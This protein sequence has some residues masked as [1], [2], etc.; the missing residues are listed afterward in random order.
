[1]M[2]RASAVY[3]WIVAFS[4][5]VQAAEIE[6]VPRGTETLKI[7]TCDIV[8][9]FGSACCGI[10]MKAFKAVTAYLEGARGLSRVRR[11]SW[12]LEGEQT[13]CIGTA[14]P[15]AAH[16][17]VSAINKLLPAGIDDLRPVRVSRPKSESH[18]P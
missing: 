15:A 14:T 7:E 1:M 16:N 13:Y 11:Y 8:V 12:G 6:A 4:A 2:Q 17:V 5:T 10:D 3:A 18:A 9:E